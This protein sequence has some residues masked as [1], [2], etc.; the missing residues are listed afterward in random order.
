MGVEQCR[1]GAGGSVAALILCSRVITHHALSSRAGRGI[2]ALQ[3]VCEGTRVTFYPD[4][5]RRSVPRRG[6][7]SVVHYMWP[8]TARQERAQLNYD[9]FM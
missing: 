6:G 1:W 5:G 9:G 7:A 8:R 2:I 3:S 4:R